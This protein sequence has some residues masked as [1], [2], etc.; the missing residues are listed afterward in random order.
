MT[1]TLT[2]LK[3]VAAALV[4]A[5]ALGASTASA[6]GGPGL[7]AGTGCA[8]QCIKK[9]LVTAT[10][11]A[12][13]VELETTV[14]AH[15]RVSVVKQ[16]TSTTAGGFTTNQAKSVAVSAFSPNKT[17]FFLGLEPDT[18]YV[19]VVR[20]TDLQQRRTTREGTFRTLPVKTNGNAGPGNIDSGLGCAAQCIE[21]AL[22]TQRPPA[23]SI[24]DVDIRASTV[25]KIQIV[26]SRDKPAQTASGPAQFDVVSAQASPGLTRSWQ[27]QVGGLGAGTRYYVVVRAKDAQGRMSIRQGSFKTVS[28]SAVVTIHKIKVVG[29]GDKG[30]NKGELYFRLWVG[31]DIYGR[32]GSGWRKLGSGSVLSV[33][34]NGTTRPGYRFT[35]PAN[36]DGRFSM[37]ML[38]EECDAVLEKNCIIEASGQSGGQYAEAGGSFRVAE[39]LEG[40]ALPPW[41]GTG[42]E[43]PAGH[44]GY[45]V[46]GTTEKYVKFLVLA[47]VDLETDWP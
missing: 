42:V 40:G 22:F 44:D 11:T 36:G 23:A 3:P 10:A 15:L 19:I 8:V 25:A 27:T 47:T 29:D 37:S 17:A 13:K 6:A 21:R 7:T 30:S 33:K 24:A 45:F 31:D 4:A 9:A 14:S 38:G 41:Y 35:V 39:L 16:S 20:A 34:E 32:W 46:L 1:R 12:A 5:L 28:A 26:V 18:T 43:A 2:H